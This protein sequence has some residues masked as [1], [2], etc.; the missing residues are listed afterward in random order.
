MT[1]S[2]QS[3]PQ[4]PEGNNQAARWIVSHGVKPVR[5]V[6]EPVGYLFDLLQSKPRELIWKPG[7]PLQ[8][9]TSSALQLLPVRLQI[10][11]QNTEPSVFALRQGSVWL[12][13]INQLPL[14]IALL[15]SLDIS[16]WGWHQV[17]D[18]PI[19]RKRVAASPVA[20]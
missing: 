15:D 4:T 17:G 14:L 18:A 12:A 7:Y 13:T 9:N 2:I 16:L 1:S 8:Q 3:F 6:Q 20:A 10:T 19:G 5:P 11:R